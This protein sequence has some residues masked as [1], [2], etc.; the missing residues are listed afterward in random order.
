[1]IHYDRIIWNL[2]G[3]GLSIRAIA[4][5]IGCAPSNI[6]RLQTHHGEPRMV[7]AL[8]LLDLHYDLCPTRHRVE[9]IG[10]P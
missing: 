3:S 1:M 2:R 7:T 4:R 5:E 8:Q 9:L 6:S 10:R